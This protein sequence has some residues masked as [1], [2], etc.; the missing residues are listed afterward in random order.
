MHR[1]A[2]AVVAATAAACAGQ[3]SPTVTEAEFLSALQE[4]HPALLARAEGIAVAEAELRRRGTLANPRLEATHED[5]SG[6]TDQIDLTLTWQL[7]RPSRRAAVASGQRGLAAAQARLAFDRIVLRLEMREVYA[8][9]AVATE[10]ASR[11]GDH[12]RTVGELA[13]RERRRAEHGETSGLAAD[14]LALAAAE[15][16][17]QH[18][19]LES[20]SIYAAAR[21]RGW[22]PSMSRRSRP[23]LS[24]LPP[25]PVGAGDE[26]P[27]VT[28]LE[29]ELEA[30]KLTQEAEGRYIELPELIAGWQQVDAGPESL[31]GPILGLS[32]QLP[33]ADRN[34]AERAL[35]EAR[36]EAA[37]ARLEAARRT[38]GAG[39]E[40][41][42]ASY[43][44]L[45]EATAA[46]RG[47][48][49][50]NRQILSAEA[51]A[52]QAGEASLTDL[53]DTLRSVLAAEMTT[54][55]VHAAAL[56]AHRRLERF[57]GRPLDLE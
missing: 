15:L 44:R 34:R 57:E 40:G 2:F 12:A 24:R 38:I 47:A 54:L 10:L 50:G 41:A 9:W 1:F 21:A 25:N 22:N 32:W 8:D 14:R 42:R 4:D 46:A 37:T 23:S 20:D 43:Q 56:E 13:T 17:A 28:E 55:R 18:A 6:P 52:F 51:A 39:R 27:T 5:P 36:I 3:S 31:D 11:V 53:L 29:Q 33:L 26:H 16:L 48:N 30:A 19:I 35:A 45:A 49:T 7:P